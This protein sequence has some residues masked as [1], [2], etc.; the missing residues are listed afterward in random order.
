M[1]T[2]PTTPQPRALPCTLRETLTAALL[3]AL[4]L[5]FTVHS[6]QAGSAT[7]NLNPTSGDWNTA[8]NWTP[9]TVP[10]AVNDTA[11]FG[12]S[13]TTNVTLSALTTLDGITFDPGASGFTIDGARQTVKIM[14]AG[15]TNNSGVTQNFAS[16]YN[17]SFNGSATAGDLTSY[18]LTGLYANF[19]DQSSAGSATITVA[20]VGYLYFRST[21]TA[22]NATLIANSGQLFFLD[23]ATA[24]NAT[25]IADGGSIEITDSSTGGTAR[26]ILHD[27]MFLLFDAHDAPGVTI[28]S[29]EGSGYVYI[30]GSAAPWN[31]TV[32]SNNLSTTFSGTISNPYF[33]GGFSKIGTGT[34]ILSNANN[35]S[36]GTLVSSGALLVT[37]TSGSGT[38]TGPVHVDAGTLGGTGGISG[39]VTVGSGTSGAFLAP[40]TTSKVGTLFITNTLTFKSHS[41]YRVKLNS[42]AVKI[43]KVVALGVNIYNRA[44]IAL[45]DH[46]SA[47]LTPGTIITLISNTSAT[48]IA[49]T[50][51]NLPDGGTITVGS[52]TFQANY[53]GG[54]GNDLTLT[55]Q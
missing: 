12:T 16:A 32:G 46:G 9:A 31:L 14:G 2:Q 8:A 6:G 33:V 52:N 7:W 38:G 19:Y 24:G 35:Y 18:L 54:D 51:K 4:L 25:L 55:V 40:G 50:F 43:D 22:A 27:Q 36:G 1:K 47:V 41:T 45:E 29:L 44:L 17:L 37:N 5:L 28:G 11:T 3:P 21:S 30:G 26:V 20:G 49:G 15:V 42:N 10:N 23:S 39:P 13:N 34:L 48:P 53:E